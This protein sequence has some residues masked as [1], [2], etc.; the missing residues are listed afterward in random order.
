MARANSRVASARKGLAISRRRSV[1]PRDSGRL[2]ARDAIRPSADRLFAAGPAQGLGAFGPR[3]PAAHLDT[4]AVL[5]DRP[6]IMAGAVEVAPPLD[7]KF[8]HF[9]PVFRGVPP[10][11]AKSS[12]QM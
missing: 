7:D 2:E 9:L 3:D 5:P 6:E 11:Y 8:D 12:G 4:L 1:Q 10:A